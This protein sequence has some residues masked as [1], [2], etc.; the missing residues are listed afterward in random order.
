MIKDWG[1]PTWYFIHVFCQRINESQLLMNKKHIYDFLS[2]ILC[3]LPCPECSY[4]A[5]NFI[6][7]CNF[8][9]LQNKNQLI[10][11]FFNF[12]NTVSERIH[13]K[14]PNF[15][16]PNNDILDQYKDKNVKDAFRKYHA[17]WTKS[18]NIKNVVAMTSTFSR[19]RFMENTIKWMKS[20][21]HLFES[22]SIL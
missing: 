17:E 18:S 11:L 10:T 9:N 21:L 7:N 1:P 20:N 8:N 15:K 12:H 19:N 2:Q 22:N 13:R 4:H 6:I 3:N 16:T 14:N 5:R